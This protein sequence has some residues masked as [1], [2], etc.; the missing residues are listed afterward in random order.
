MRTNQ[1]F[2]NKAKSLKNS[3]FVVPFLVA[4]AL[5]FTA[6]GSVTALNSGAQAVRIIIDPAKCEYIG[7]VQGYKENSWGDLS[8]KDMRDSAKN[9]LKNAAHALGAN[10]VL[11]T[12]KDASKSSSGYV[13][14]LGFGGGFYG[15][16]GYV[17]TSS[18]TSEYHLEGIAYKCP[19]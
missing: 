7:E 8:L 5:F 4:T 2:T 14:H 13:T 11:I 6:C 10:A 16:S 18:K 9:E 15:G 1:K 3:R 19:F 12:D 17:N